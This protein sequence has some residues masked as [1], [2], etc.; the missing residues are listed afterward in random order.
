MEVSTVMDPLVQ[1]AIVTG[2]A[3][4]GAAVAGFL[5]D[6]VQERRQRSADLI[7]AAL[8]NFGGGSQRRSVGIAALQVLKEKSGAWKDYRD[9]VRKLY[10]AQLLYLFVHGS[11]RWEA[12]EITNMEAMMDWL[13]TRDNL[14][15]ATWD[16]GEAKRLTDAMDKYSKD[17][18]SLSPEDRRKEGGRPDEASIKHIRSRMSGWKKSLDGPST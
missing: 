18:V 1:A 2:A 6:L 7:I 16:P 4:L 5:S 10:Y 3:A 11:N 17:Y 15:P 12:H 14:A 13:V 8:G 9:T